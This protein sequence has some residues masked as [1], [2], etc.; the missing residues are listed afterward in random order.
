MLLLLL[1]SLLMTMMYLFSSVWFDIAVLINRFLK[2]HTPYLDYILLCFGHTQIPAMMWIVTFRLHDGCH[3]LNEPRSR[4]LL[5]TQVVLSGLQARLIAG[6]L[7]LVTPSLQEDFTRLSTARAVPPRDPC[8]RGQRL[9]WKNY[10]LGWSW[11]HLGHVDVTISG[12]VVPDVTISG[13]VESDV[14]I[15]RSIVPD[16]T[17]SGRVVPDVTISGSVVPDV[18]ISGGVVPDV[19]IS[20]SVVPDV[21]ISGSV[22]PDVTISVSVVPDMTISG[23][24][25]P[26]GCSS[27]RE[28]AAKPEV[29]QCALLF[30]PLCQGGGAQ[31]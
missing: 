14:T 2:H 1:L 26:A 3:S 24:V 5:D 28:R 10:C 13:S 4:F 12:S 9:D 15:C 18:T 25:V 6:Y 23:R 27:G 19:T 22:V 17:I 8:A 20:V 7:H 30:P 29:T 31:I 11:M 21:T 16:V